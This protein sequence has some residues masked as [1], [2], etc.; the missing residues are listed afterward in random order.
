MAGSRR[1]NIEPRMRVVGYT[2]RR[3]DSAYVGRYGESLGFVI[4]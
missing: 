1:P 3:M 2:R 4:G